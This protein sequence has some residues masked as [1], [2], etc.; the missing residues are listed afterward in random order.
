MRITF[1]GGGVM[2]EAM[3]KC[4]VDQKV[5]S[6][7]DIVISDINELRREMLAREYKVKASADSKRAVESADV[8][9]LAIKP[10]DL[11]EVMEAI[12]D[13][14][15]QQAVLSIVAG[16]SLA[17]LTNGLG[18]RNVIRAMPNMPAQIGLGMTVWTTTAEL[19][20]ERKKIA[21]SILSAL[22]REIYFTDEKYINMATALS[23]SGPAYVFLF[24]EA[25]TD[26][27]VNIGLS[28]KE[29]QELALQTILGSVEM[30]QKV[31]KHPAELRNMVTSPGGTTA[32]ALAQLEK[33]GFRSSVL[34]AVVAAYEKARQL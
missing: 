16:A 8:I 34:E 26:A 21:R 11:A 30:V 13:S 22:G 14:L 9:V 1:I 29:A 15:K 19:S 7:S 4:L 32:A 6:P 24:I 3:V 33:G 5:V 20:K 31:G 10:G 17:T 18:Y 2:G 12:K 28:C 27:G 25:L 23:G